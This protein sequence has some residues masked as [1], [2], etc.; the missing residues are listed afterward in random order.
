MGRAQGSA[1]RLGLIDAASPRALFAE[2]VAGAL[3]ETGVSPTPMAVAYLVELLEGRVRAPAVGCEPPLAEDLLRARGLQ[4]AA[5]IR[6]LRALGDR[7]LFVSG[8][9]GDSLRRRAVDLATY[10]EAG[11]VAYGDL[12][13]E[14]A[15]RV[16][17]RGWACLFEELAD[18]FR[19]FVDVLAE[20]GD[21]TA[22][23]RPPDLLRLFER[24]LETGSPGDLRRLRRRGHLPL[25]LPGLRRWQ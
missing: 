2:L 9:F 1:A 21:R 22:G 23:R 17:E 11:R 5:R 8:F 12:A 20:V 15:L 16:R 18:R 25:P 7:A 14:L 13:R 24:Y 6:H 10:G 3:G 4:G 19:D